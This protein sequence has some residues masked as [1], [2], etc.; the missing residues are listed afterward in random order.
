MVG[1][2]V[3]ADAL[4]KQQAIVDMVKDEARSEYTSGVHPVPPPP[5]TP[6][7]PLGPHPSHK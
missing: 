3:D 6:P 5:P 2:S 1:D 7:P 4:S